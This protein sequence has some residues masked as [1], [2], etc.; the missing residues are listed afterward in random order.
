MGC[1]RVE[2]SHVGQA[3][4]FTIQAL[5]EPAQLIREGLHH[6]HLSGRICVALISWGLDLRGTD[7]EWRTSLH[8]LIEGRSVFEISEHVC[9]ELLGLSDNI[10]STVYSILILH[11]SIQAF[12][13]KSPYQSLMSTK[14]SEDTSLSP[15]FHFRTQ[16][17]PRAWVPPSIHACS[18][19]SQA[20]W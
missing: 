3:S 18:A 4:G 15:Q 2:R 5:P 20:Y 14:A 6:G 8:G 10:A 16:M 11:L 7:C 9:T 19:A 1:T 13:R 12:H 17:L